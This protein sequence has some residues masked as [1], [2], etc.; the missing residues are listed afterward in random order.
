MKRLGSCTRGHEAPGIPCHPSRT[1]EFDCLRSQSNSP[2]LLRWRR[3]SIEFTRSTRVAQECTKLL[4]SYDITDD[5]VHSCWC[6]F[7][8]LL[9]SMHRLGNS[10]TS[11]SSSLQLELRCILECTLYYY[12]GISLL[13]LIITTRP[14]D[15]G[16][17]RSQALHGLGCDRRRSKAIEL[18]AIEL[19]RLTQVAQYAKCCMVWRSIEGN[20]THLFYLC[21]AVRQSN[22]P[23]SGGAVCYGILCHPSLTGEF[24]C[25]RLIC[26]LC[27]AWHLVLPKSNGQVRL[28]SIA[29]KSM[30]C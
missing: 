23:D 29:P 1:G 20:R 22:S 30:K 7:T 5:E 24:D 27:S 4:A 26:R 14:F 8:P 16:G 10:C 2:I 21:G 17:A 18:E 9:L 25:L 28:P 19:T 11:C 12:T 13:P 3:K 6:M 15:S